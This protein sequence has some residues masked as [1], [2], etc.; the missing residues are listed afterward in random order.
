[1]DSHL[2]LGFHVDL[3]DP[4]PHLAGVAVQNL[5]LSVTQLQD[6][7]VSTDYQAPRVRLESYTVDYFHL[8]SGLI[9]LT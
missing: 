7:E 9:C 4:P 8:R 3:S 2:Q 1:M 6:D 5:D